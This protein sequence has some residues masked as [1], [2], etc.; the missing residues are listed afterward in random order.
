MTEIASFHHMILC[1]RLI[2]IMQ[3]SDNQC[4][5]KCKKSVHI[6]NEMVLCFEFSSYAKAIVK[7]LQKI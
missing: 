1:I 7:L 3:Q 5:A 4:I 2:V 6:W